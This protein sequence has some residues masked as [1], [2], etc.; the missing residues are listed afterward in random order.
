MWPPQKHTLPLALPWTCP[1]GLFRDGDQK[2]ANGGQLRNVPPTESI[3]WEAKG[4]VKTNY[5]FLSLWKST[6][7]S[8]QSRQTFISRGDSD[9]RLQALRIFHLADVLPEKICIRT[10][11]LFPRS[12]FVISTEN[13]NPL[14]VTLQ[15]FL[16]QSGVL[17]KRRITASIWKVYGLSEELRSQFPRKWPW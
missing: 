10:R 16:L 13:D 17:P 11:C 6:D 3:R 14:F 2:Q 5:K 4:L 7:H 8:Q 12:P 1:H 15:S 9:S